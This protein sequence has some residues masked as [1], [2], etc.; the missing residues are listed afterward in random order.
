MAGRTASAVA[1][2]WRLRKSDAF[3]ECVPSFPKDVKEQW[4][5]FI[6]TRTRL[7]LEDRRY[8]CTNIRP[9]GG[10][11]GR[12]WTLQFP[13]GIVGVF[14]TSRHSTP[15]G[16]AGCSFPPGQSAPWAA[17]KQK[18]PRDPRVRLPSAKTEP[19]RK[20]QVQN[21]TVTGL[22]KTSPNVHAR[23]LQTQRAAPVLP[24]CQA[25]GL[26]QG[27]KALILFRATGTGISA[28]AVMAATS[29]VVSGD[30]HSK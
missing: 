29:K 24:R 9:G 16:L 15:G 5:K 17:Q 11:G 14:T 18:L 19:T 1:K 8:T 13:R 27:D 22:L 26:G 30:W 21:A 6:H 2:D 7:S 23:A 10:G 28:T 20:E 12:N 25:H 4:R 3:P